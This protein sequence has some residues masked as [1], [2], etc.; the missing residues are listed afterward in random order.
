M[1]KALSSTAFWIINKSIAK[2]YG[3]DAALLLADLMAKRDYF[4]RRN[5]L[6][7]DGSFFNT[8]DNLERDLSLSRD[9]R[10]AAQRSLER[11]GLIYIKRIGMPSKN[12]FLIND[13]RIASVLS[14]EQARL[15]SVVLSGGN[16]STNKIK[17]KD[18]KQNIERLGGVQF[19][20]VEEEKC[21]AGA[22][23]VTRLGPDSERAQAILDAQGV[24]D[25][26]VGSIR[27]WDK[28]GYPNGLPT[29]ISPGKSMSMF[30]LLEVWE[31]QLLAISPEGKFRMDSNDAYCMLGD[32][33][34]ENSYLDE[35]KIRE[36]FEA[37][38]GKPTASLAYKQFETSP[39][40][41][42]MIGFFRAQA[43]KDKANGVV[44]YRS[45]HKDKFDLICERLTNE[46]GEDV[47][48]AFIALIPKCSGDL[49]LA[50]EAAVSNVSA[51]KSE[52]AG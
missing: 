7:S 31:A 28:K 25:D 34:K 49:D 13:V 1:S 40:I 15:D 32:F 50:E 46:Y 11:D 44:Q 4:R 9:R 30:Q 19:S 2:K 51:R 29:S 36:L 10:R 41:T 24:T 52:E 3:F 23:K 16:S 39:D 47:A 8:A 21:I 45:P 43:E 18:N 6:Q 12:Y 26:I 20:P 38:V 17:D 27:R 22:F 5:Q 35:P 33:V 42:W 48:M 14:V 37:K